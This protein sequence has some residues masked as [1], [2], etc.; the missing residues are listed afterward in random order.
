MAHYRRKHPRTRSRTGINKRDPGW[1][2]LNNWPKWWDVIFHT[3]PARSRAKAT[4]H[5]VARD[6]D[7]WDDTA[8][9]DVGKKPHKTIGNLRRLVW[10]RTNALIRL[11][12]EQWQPLQSRECLASTLGQTV[13]TRQVTTRGGAC[14]YTVIAIKCSM[15]QIA[16]PSRCGL[17]NSGWGTSAPGAA[18]G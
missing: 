5:N 14:V 6:P 15:A 17:T 12:G 3:R 1:Y 16:N 8:Y 4:T 2:W 11:A 7:L 10:S 13:P 18:S 9:Y